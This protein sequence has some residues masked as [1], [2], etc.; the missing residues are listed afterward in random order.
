MA[1]CVTS[2]P[3]LGCTVDGHT[4]LWKIGHKKS[5]PFFN[6]FL[7]KNLPVMHVR[8]TTIFAGQT[9][10]FYRSVTGDR[11]LF[12]DL[13]ARTFLFLDFAARGHLFKGGLALTSLLKFNPLFWFVYFYTSVYFKT[14][15]K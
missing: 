3:L 10:K 8:Q 13:H 2:P 15:E 11:H 14:S 7:F 12:R 9:V 6:A 5:A 1:K 4:L